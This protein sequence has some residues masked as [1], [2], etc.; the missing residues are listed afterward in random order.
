LV[1]SCSLL[2]RGIPNG[3]GIGGRGG[4][5]AWRAAVCGKVGVPASGVV[6]PICVSNDTDCGVGEVMPSGGGMGWTGSMPGAAAMGSVV[7]AITG[8]NGGGG[9]GSDWTGSTPGAPAMGS[10]VLTIPGRNGR[11]IRFAWSVST[12]VFPF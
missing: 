4:C 9:M 8:R 12:P 7:L 3:E 10:V 1:G 6:F 2:D 11:G 5:S